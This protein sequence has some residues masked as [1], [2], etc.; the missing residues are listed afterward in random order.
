[1]AAPG[2]AKPTHFKSADAFRVWLSRHGDSET[3][4]W[5]AFYKKSSGKAGMTYPEALDEAL[6]HGW[7][8]GVRKSADDERYVQRFSPRR[9]G[10]IWSNV[11]IRKVKALTDAGRMT[12]RGLRIFNDRDPRQNAK[13][14]FEQGD[15]KLANEDEKIFRKSN[16]GWKFFQA[17]PPGY[18]KVATW[19]IVSAKRDETRLKR[20]KTL[21]KLSEHGERLPLLSSTPVKK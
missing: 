6:A 20:L 13:Y 21:V 4:L 11:N 3:E 15:Q 16:A 19:W 14:S 18:R 10:S 5:V 1:M 17:Q 9:P 12:E 8:D 2:I 7:I